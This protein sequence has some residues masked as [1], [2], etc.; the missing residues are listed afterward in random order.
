MT[1]ELQEKVNA[2]VRLIQSAGYEDGR[3]V[4]VAY[5]GGKDSDVIL[6]LT[7]MAG[8]PYRAIYHNTTI[9]PPGTIKHVKEQGA[10]IAQPPKTFFQLIQE[11]GMPNRFQRYCCRIIKEHKTLDRCIMGIRKA[12]STE[13][14][15]NYEEPTECRYYGSGRKTKKNHVEAIY[16]ILTWT[17]E[18]VVEFIEER[19]I[20]L[21]P[22]YYRE[23]G[24]IDSKRRLGCMCCP[25]AYYR[26]R[27]DYFRRYPGMV[28][29]YCRAAERYRQ[30]HPDV[31]TVGKYSDVYEWFTREVFFERQSWWEDHKTVTQF[32]PPQLPRVPGTLFRHRIII[33]E[34]CVRKRIYD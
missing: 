26:K 15:K 20:R 2:A 27:I 1:E 13:R 3:P 4:E 7:R 9:D 14:D 34:I 11:M 25:L 21:H 28:R 18:D 30:S 29:A 16:P 23:D 10:E 12:E 22:L 32:T 17:D 33:R 19:G 31:E 8:I 6:E 24:T 5:S